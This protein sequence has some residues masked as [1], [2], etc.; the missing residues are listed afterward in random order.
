MS[1]DE[2]LRAVVC[3]ALQA[4]VPEADLTSL[5]HA[6]PFRDQMEMDSIDFVNFMLRLEKALGGHIGEADYPLLS[7][8]D[9]CLDYLRRENVC[10][11]QQ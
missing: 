10:G 6:L 9:G 4:V 8:L 1:S 11:G 7:T 3:A 2:S 5:D